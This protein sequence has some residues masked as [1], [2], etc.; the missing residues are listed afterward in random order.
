M[1]SAPNEQAPSSTVTP[2]ENILPD[3]QR[4]TGL[5]RW[6]QIAIFVMVIGI[7]AFFAFGLKAR[8]EAQPSTGAAPEF[9]LQTFDGKTVKL[10]DLRGK[11]VVINFWASWCVPC[12]DE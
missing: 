5:P 8:G 4:T 11:V 2:A 12:R 9:T 7:I 3:T 10:A 6:V 1:Q